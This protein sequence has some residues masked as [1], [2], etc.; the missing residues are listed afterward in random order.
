MALHAF[1]RMLQ[2]Q[3]AAAVSAFAAADAF[4]RETSHRQQRRQPL[5]LC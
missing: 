1:H 4:G 2:M 3:F 5:A